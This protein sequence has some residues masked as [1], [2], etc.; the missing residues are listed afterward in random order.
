MSA[1]SAGGF[2]VAA[3]RNTRS[4]LGIDLGIAGIQGVSPAGRVWVAWVQ[5]AGALSTVHGVQP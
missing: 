3:L 2:V 4:V 1:P 5:G